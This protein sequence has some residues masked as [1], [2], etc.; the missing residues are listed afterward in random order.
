MLKLVLDPEK[1][2][3]LLAKKQ[4]SYDT[5]ASQIKIVYQP[6]DRI[7]EEW[8]RGNVTLRWRVAVAEALNVSVD[9]ISPTKKKT[10][11]RLLKNVPIEKLRS[12]KVADAGIT[13]AAIGSWIDGGGIDIERLLAVAKLFGVSPHEL[14]SNETKN[15]LAALSSAE[16]NASEA[17]VRK[18][19][20]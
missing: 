2:R 11:A 17:D 7:L 5:I 13:R 20:F 3:E 10:A 4:W 9:D 18:A 6:T 14:L 12:V 1:V 15:L 8:L 19:M 16:I